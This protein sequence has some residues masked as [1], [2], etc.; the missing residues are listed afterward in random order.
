[1]KKF[2]VVY[3]LDPNSPHYKSRIFEVEGDQEQEIT[4]DKPIQVR[5]NNG[6]W[7]DVR[8]SDLNNK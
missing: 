4:A 8:Q 3:D 6:P 7:I 1:M 2:P 5:I